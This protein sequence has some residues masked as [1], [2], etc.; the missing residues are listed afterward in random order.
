MSSN[1][2][3]LPAMAYF[4]AGFSGKFPR[5]LVS[6][7]WR[8]INVWWKSFCHRLCTCRMR[9]RRVNQNISAIMGIVCAAGSQLRV[10]ENISRV[11]SGCLRLL[12]SAPDALAHP[13]RGVP[14]FRGRW[15][16]VRSSN[17]PQVK[18][19]RS[20]QGCFC[21]FVVPPK[22]QPYSTTA[23]PLSRRVGLCGDGAQGQSEAYRKQL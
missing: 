23:E 21:L 10:H 22:F 11:A 20:V 8:A 15:F 5:R 4:T 16:L 12:S 2:Q 17:C 6:L 1:L 9:L 7:V 3:T 14:S 18:C 19:R 13:I